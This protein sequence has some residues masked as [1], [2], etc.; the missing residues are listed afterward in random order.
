MKK[1]DHVKIN[2]S[3]NDI[4]AILNEAVKTNNIAIIHRNLDRLY[5]MQKHYIN[6]LN[7][8]DIEIRIL[9]DELRDNRKLLDSYEKEWLI[10]ITKRNGI[11][12]N[13]KARID[14]E[15]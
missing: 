2:R 5:A 10:E 1:I 14:K 12:E 3:N 15:V 9:I 8:Q 13:L 7:F 11:Y 6:L 4:W